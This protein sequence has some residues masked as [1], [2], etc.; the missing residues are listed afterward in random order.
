MDRLACIDLPAFPLQ[1]LLQDHPEWRGLPAA[2][3]AEDKPQAALL[4]VNEHARRAGILPGQR[5]AAALSL[6]L[7]LR[8]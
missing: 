3:V 8:A 1:L 4:W 5:Y 2:V 6:A 7:D